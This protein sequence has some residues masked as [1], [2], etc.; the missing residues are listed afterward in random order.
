MHATQ[1]IF[2]PFLERV[3]HKQGLKHTASVSQ[4]IY[5]VA[6]QMEKHWPIMQALNVVSV[7]GN[8]NELHHCPR[9]VRNLFQK[10]CGTRWLSTEKRCE[11]FVRILNI[12]APPALEAFVASKMGGTESAEWQRIRAVCTCLED[13]S[14][15]S[16]II[17][18]FL[19]IANHSAGGV[20]GEGHRSGA[21]LVAFM[22]SPLQ[23]VSIVAAA[24]MAAVHSRWAAF[25]DHKSAVVT[26]AR[27][28]S[29]RVIELPVFE[30]E[31]LEWVQ[32][33]NHDWRA[34]LPSVV[35]AIN[36]ESMRAERLHLDTGTASIAD[37]I[38]QQIKSGV[39]EMVATADKYLARTLE[40]ID[41]HQ[42]YAPLRPKY[43][44]RT[45]LGKGLL[46]GG[47]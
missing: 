17:A 33:L 7:G 29:T 8:A 41:H 30:R 3:I 18:M 37:T 19:H 22:C 27:M 6:Y 1:N 25:A 28:G 47:A 16:H 39:K 2:K 46:I 4:N 32:S 34:A 24:A 40:G 44:S 13:E 15:L 5:S 36:R 21:T 9:P 10:I 12:P 14:Q 43:P 35:D 26:A 45:A 42:Y 20:S 31:A 23:R 11:E 38:E